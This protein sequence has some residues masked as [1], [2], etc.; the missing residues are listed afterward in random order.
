MAG[1]YLCGRGAVD[2]KGPTFAILKALETLRRVEGGLP[3]NVK[4]VMEGERGAWRPVDRGLCAVQTRAAAADCVLILDTG[5]AARG[6]PTITYGLRGI[7]TFEIAARARGAR[8]AL[9]A[10]W[11]R[12]AQ[13]DPGALLGAGRSQRAGRPHQFARA[14]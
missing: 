14:V 9:R 13:P 10:V 3:L 12:R 1:D 11:R 8:L 6:V 7:I 5:M 4:V 2:D